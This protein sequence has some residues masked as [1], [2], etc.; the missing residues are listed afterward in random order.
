MNLLLVHEQPEVREILRFG[1]ETRFT[2]KIFEAGGGDEAQALLEQFRANRSAL[3]ILQ[4]AGSSHDAARML[5]DKTQFDL[6]ICQFGPAASRLLD[7]VKTNQIE[8]P[9]VL[10]N[11]GKTPVNKG[12]ESKIHKV[13]SG[14][15]VLPDI[16][17]ILDELNARN[18]FDESAEKKEPALD[19]LYCPIKTPLLIR[20]C[21]LKS[22]IYIR[23]SEKKFVK[24]FPEG[25]TF[26]VSDLKKY[27]KEKKVEYMYL[28][29][30]ECAEFLSKFKSDLDDLINSEEVDIEEA[31]RA[32]ED[33]HET[34][35]HLLARTGF[36]DDVQEIARQS[37]KLT[38][39]VM[40]ESPELITILNR[41]K[42][43]REKYI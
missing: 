10:W 1:I 13:I 34:M 41:L 42:E 9:F 25:A 33:A 2:I 8:A 12:L 5:A 29:R 38:L 36:T 26:D 43:N 18:R 14:K 11:T 24:L 40:G 30:D 37:V 22:D 19:D 3:E 39:K 32:V 16:V 31:S 4:K 28:H 21:P 23:L 7:F 6:I 35:Q 27:Y 15:E 20:V 17:T